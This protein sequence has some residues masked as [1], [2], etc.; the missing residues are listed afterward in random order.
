MS[1]STE[2]LPP[3]E[4]TAD[5]AEAA[6]DSTDADDTAILAAHFRALQRLHSSVEH[7]LRSPLNSIG[8]NLELLAAEIGD[9]A[10]RERGDSPEGRDP[11]AALGQVLTALRGGYARLIE[12]TD[13][14]I[15]VVLPGAS[16][17]EAVDLARLARRV[18]GLGGT[19]S[20]LV[21]ATWQA[22]IPPGP[23]HLETQSGLLMPALL[24][25][26]CSALEHAGAGSRITFSVAA[27]PEAAEVRAEVEPCRDPENPASAEERWRDLALLARRLGGSC[28]ESAEESVFRIH[29]SLPRLFGA[30]AC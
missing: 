21:R 4:G 29:L 23:I 16:R 15:H 28:G 10:E 26:I 8:L 2:P 24:A 11:A 17:V 12:S 22:D 9:L 25:L 5:P 20:V 3:Y 30:A 14:V 18:A 6:A 13:S 1:A 19:E 27:G 7:Q